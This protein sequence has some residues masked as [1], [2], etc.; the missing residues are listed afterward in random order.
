MFFSTSTLL[1]V[2]SASTLVLAVPLSA[3]P[4]GARSCGCSVTSAQ[5]TVPAGQSSIAVP[6][7]TPIYVALGLG[8]QVSLARLLA[9]E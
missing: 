3:G 5:L 7:G 6:T 9:F 4:I 2:L 8:I 1:S